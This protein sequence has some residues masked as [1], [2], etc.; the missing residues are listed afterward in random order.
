[1][2]EIG[3]LQAGQ[4][5]NQIGAKFWEPYNVTLSVYQLVENSDETFCIDNEALYDICSAR[6]NSRRTATL[7]ISS[8]ASCLALPLACVSLV[9]STHDLRKL[10]VNMVPF[11]CLHFFMTGFAPLTAHGSAQ[12]RAVSIP[13][14]T[15]QMFDANNMMAA[16]DPRHGRCLTVAAGPPSSGRDEGGR[17][18]DAERTEQ[19]LGVLRRVDLQQRPHRPL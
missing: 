5:G 18:A 9:N 12:F 19:K 14:L 1:M 6:S 15:Q 10:A 16:S 2:R 11:P 4:C 8:P 3:H 7:T 17:G 13:E